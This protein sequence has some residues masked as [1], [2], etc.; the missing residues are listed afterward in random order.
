MR[1]EYDT[2]SKQSGFVIYIRDL[3][4]C[5]GAVNELSNAL[6]FRRRELRTSTSHCLLQYQGRRFLAQE[7]WLP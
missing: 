2:S 3:R 4:I 7:F 5:I 1:Q 6:N